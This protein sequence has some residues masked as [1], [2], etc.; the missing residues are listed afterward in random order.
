MARSTTASTALSLLATAAILGALPAVLAHGDDEGEGMAAPQEDQKL[1][2]YPP[3]YFSHPEHRGVMYAHIVL[4]VLGWVFVL[5]IAV[6]FSIARSR[7]TLLTQFV[8]LVTNA[9]G[10]VLGIS[11]NA[12]TPDLY[13]NNA[14]HKIGWIA[15]WM[16]C[17][18]VLISLIGRVAGVMSREEQNNKEER[19]AFIPV[20]TRNMEEHL[21]GN[22]TLYHHHKYSYSNDSGQGTEPGT[23]SLRSDSLS[24]G[25]ESPAETSDHPRMDYD[26]EDLEFKE[27]EMKAPTPPTNSLVA[28]IA[29]KISSR[30]WKFLLLGYNI[31]DRTSLILGY[32][33]LTTG[34]VTWARFF[35]GHE[36]FGG[37][38][39]WI[40]GGVFFWLGLFYLGRW[41]GS[42]GELG[43][44]W[45][46]RPK[47]S[48][49]KWRPS[50]EF[51]E[52]GLIFFYGSTN[53]FL[54]HLGNAG[55]AFSAQ[56]LEHVSITVLFIGGGLLAMLVESTRIR[57][58]L[59]MTVSEA[60]EAHP[61][62]THTDEDRDALR[63]PK[64]Y[65]FSINPIPALVI[66][67]TGIMMSSHTQQSML[68]SM[69]HKQW[70]NLLTAAAFARGFTYVLL[71]LKP[72]T[73][74]MP[75]RPPT[76]LL[77][78]FG[79]IAGGVIFCASSSD[80]VAG[81]VHYDLDEMFVY[82]VTMGCVGML[83]A[84]VIV[85]LALKGWAVR[86]EKGPSKSAWIAQV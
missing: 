68:S 3:T 6:M 26:D 4:M 36:I 63:A 85:M 7:Y 13:P 47:Q 84:W 41:A 34:I 82:T 55:Q 20:S 30:A 45:N 19:Q 33:A 32:I 25:Q 49:P 86:R 60:A 72:P 59:N 2:S 78:S 28:K 8:F 39:H 71:Y 58:L 53:I 35:E 14:H 27:V 17:A 46:V 21:R 24:S 67:L 15:T 83:M 81:M 54:E 80:T 73:S 62:H 52:G 29:G 9:L 76:E 50:A 48:T 75:S 18:Q 23:E 79:L 42:F 10:V 31:I 5:P 51:V 44:A 74:V 12:S 77:T 57:E 70:G 37:L 16:M 64:Q 65:E 11:Y 66:M 38:A 40:K 56:D 22:G 43:W 69:V 61:D 1:D